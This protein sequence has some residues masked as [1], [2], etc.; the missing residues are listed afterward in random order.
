MLTYACSYCRIDLT[1]IRSEEC[2]GSI[3]CEVPFQEGDEQS[4]GHYD[5]ECAPGHSG[6]MPGLLNKDVPHRQ[7]CIVRRFPETAA[8]SCWK[9]R[10]GDRRWSPATSNR[11]HKQVYRSAD[12]D[13]C[14]WEDTT[15]IEKGRDGYAGMTLGLDSHRWRRTAAQVIEV[16]VCPMPGNHFRNR[17]PSR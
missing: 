2:L 13:Y 15:P 4:T 10:S 9:E 17:G 8:N 14:E 1:I 16:R 11:L 7:D 5:E 6:C 12:S 3:L